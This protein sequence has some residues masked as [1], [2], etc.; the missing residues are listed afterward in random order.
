MKLWKSSMLIVGI[1][2]LVLS[3]LTASAET[4]TDGI[5]DVYH[6]EYS[7]TSWNWGYNVGDKPN[8]DIT[9]VTYTVSGTQ[10]TLTLTVDGTIDDSELVMYFA[11]YN[12]DDASYWMSYANGQGLSMYSTSTGGGVG[13]TPTVS[14]NTLSCT[15]DSFEGDP[16]D[17]EA[18]GT[19][20]QYTVA[21]DATVEYW[22]DWA[23][24]SYFEGG[25]GDGDN[26]DD[27]NGDNGSGG[28][29]PGFETL[30]VIAAL[31][32]ALIILRRRK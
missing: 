10:L 13:S 28:G 23:P 6:W 12:S 3:S 19:G 5:D 15:F 11:Y 14:G 4:I 21:G 7:E 2:V 25:N 26:G 16:A 29:T 22:V 30:V 24:D 1:S 18:Y 8:I 20:Y 31:G 32:I 27:G 17:F 9:E